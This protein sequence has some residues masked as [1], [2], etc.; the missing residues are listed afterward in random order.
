MELHS[1]CGADEMPMVASTPPQLPAADPAAH[2]LRPR[3]FARPSGHPQSLGVPIKQEIKQETKDQDDARRSEPR[4]RKRRF[5]K[6]T[7]TVRK[8]RYLY[9]L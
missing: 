1:P 3:A 4:P 8:V 2:D 5:R 6:A 9:R 7:H